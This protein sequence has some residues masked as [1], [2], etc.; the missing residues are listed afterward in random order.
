MRDK[1]WSI[2]G[3]PCTGFGVWLVPYITTSLAYQTIIERLRHGEVLLD[4]GCFIGNELRELV[5]G[6]APSDNM[7]ALD[8]ISHWEI[9][10]EMYRDKST[11]KAQFIEGDFLKAQDVPQLKPLEGKVDVF[12]TCAILHLWTYE[13]QVEFLKTVVG[14]SK[15]Q[16]MIVGWNLASQK[17]YDLSFSP[18]R[19]MRLHDKESFT[20][21]WK[22]I[23]EQTGTEWEVE[24]RFLQCEDIGWD[25]RD[26]I[27]KNQ[28]VL[29]M[30]FVVT[31]VK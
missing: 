30:D 7:Y 1:A 15:P 16:S 22:E 28:D 26:N 20:Q 24:P 25:P 31:R 6:G 3:Y 14:F 12:I 10:Y 8:V 13:T 21:L 27:W 29:F 5:Y 17:P 19:S 23:G 2:R 18:G 4:I 11:F 9:G